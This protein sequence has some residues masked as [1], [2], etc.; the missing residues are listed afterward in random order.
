[1]PQID[2]GSKY[3]DHKVIALAT[4]LLPAKICS[5]FWQHTEPS[6]GADQNV[7]FQLTYVASTF[8][9]RAAVVTG[10]ET[11]QV[12]LWTATGA[13]EEPLAGLTTTQTGTR[14]PAEKRLAF[15]RLALMV[16]RL[17]GMA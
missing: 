11:G 4:G 15:A 7:D 14:R 1:M 16:A 12:C 2:T 5:K 9:E 8:F 17:A 10:A 6:G 3:F 13:P